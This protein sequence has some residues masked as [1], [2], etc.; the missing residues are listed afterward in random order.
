MYR[1]IFFLFDR[2]TIEL[3]LKTQKRLKIFFFWDEKNIL[4]RLKILIRLIISLNKM[5]ERE[6]ESLAIDIDL[7]ISTSLKSNDIV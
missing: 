6:R 1:V 4:K 5:R 3:S 7:A 2:V